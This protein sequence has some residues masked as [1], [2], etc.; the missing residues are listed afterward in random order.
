MRNPAAVSFQASEGQLPE[1]QG[2]PGTACIEAENGFLGPDL[3]R[4]A[5]PFHPVRKRVLRALSGAVRVREGFCAGSVPY[6]IIK[7]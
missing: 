7:I 1:W 4:K 5:F 2:R 3:L 6:G